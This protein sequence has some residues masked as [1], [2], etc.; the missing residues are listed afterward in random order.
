MG[1]LIDMPGGVNLSVPNLV[2]IPCHICRNLLM[3]D[4]ISVLSQTL[5]QHLFGK[6]VWTLGFSLAL[7]KARDRRYQDRLSP[8]LTGACSLG[9]R[10]LG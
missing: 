9:L 10:L 3:V 5:V 8:C 4:L 1:T 6:T 7:W 2:R